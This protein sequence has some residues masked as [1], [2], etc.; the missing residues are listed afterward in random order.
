VQ[1]ITSQREQYGVTVHLFIGTGRSS[2]EI[3]FMSL[4]T[5]YKH[6]T[7]YR[8]LDG[9][10]L[11]K[12][13]SPFISRCVVMPKLQDYSF[14]IYLHVVSAC[15]LSCQRCFCLEDLRRRRRPPTCALAHG[16]VS[17]GNMGVQC[18]AQCTLGSTQQCCYGCS[19]EAWMESNADA[20]RHTGV[21]VNM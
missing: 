18:D 21:D 6:D 14:G 19:V 3:T 2:V 9:L 4:M 13:V 5:N 15:I 7:N 17:Y 12:S 20:H 1:T 16:C 8:G 11:F 10:F